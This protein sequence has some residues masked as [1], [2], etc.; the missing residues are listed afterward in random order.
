MKKARRILTALLA[1]C[2]LGTGTP[3]AVTAN[4]VTS[5]TT[6]AQSSKPVVK[7][8][9]AGEKIKLTWSAISGAEKYRVYKYENDKLKKLTDVTKCRVILTGA[10]AS[11]TYILAVS[12]YV[13]GGWTKI[14]KNDLVKITFPGSSAIDGE[15]MLS[16]WTSDAAAKT[17]LISYMKA[18][19]TEG[20]KDYIPIENRIAVFDLDG[21]LFCETDP[22]YFDCMLLEYR[23]LEDPDY[24][25][26][27]SD[28]E[29]Q[30]AYKIKEENETGI[31]HDGIEVDHGKAVASAFKG[32][33]LDEFNDYIQKFKKQAMPGYDGMT[34]GESFYR[35][36]LQ[37][38]DYLKANDFTVYIVSGTDRFIVRSLLY[39]SA[40]DLPNKQII[41]SDQ[42]LAA[43]DQG[44]TDGLNYTFT[45]KD[46]L[47]LGGEFIIKNLKM[48]KVTVI[49]QEIG[50]K[51][52]LSF[53]NSSGDFSMNTYTITN[54]KYMS[55]AFMLCCDDTERENGNIEKAEKMYQT[56]KENNYIPISMKND[57]KTIYGDGVTY[58][59]AKAGIKPAA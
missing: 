10:K 57:W 30:V 43:D 54:N 22:N 9:I 56:C 32:M 55:L 35:P 53:G 13:N 40:L 37:I 2:M 15:E 48:N 27:A 18:I 20:S 39:N 34:R 1:A 6:E 50:E 45:D 41:G 29:K 42:L 12:A 49:A 44:D 7:A 38:I 19:T 33:T 51:P 14:T 23:V 28:F 46:E 31:S 8:T 58:K 36:M 26:K 5:V 11:S 47:I 21:T 24:K 3:G 25:D 52:V 16:L 4:A 17:E 59:G